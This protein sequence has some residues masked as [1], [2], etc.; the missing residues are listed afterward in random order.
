MDDIDTKSVIIKNKKKSLLKDVGG[1]TGR[2]TEVFYTSVSLHRNV[3]PVIFHESK[4]FSLISARCAIRRVSD[5]VSH[6]LQTPY[7]KTT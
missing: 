4:H 1:M 6:D 7:E 5:F 3:T 2:I